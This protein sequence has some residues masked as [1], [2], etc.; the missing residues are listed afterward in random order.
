MLYVPPVTIENLVLNRLKTKIEAGDLRSPIGL[1][2]EGQHI[3]SII[4][5][6]PYRTVDVLPEPTLLDFFIH[7]GAYCKILRANLAMTAD[8]IRDL[9]PN[10]DNLI[11]LARDNPNATLSDNVF[12]N[13]PAFS[14]YI[15][16][17]V[18][19]VGDIG[20]QNALRDSEF[21]GLEFFLK[22]KVY[23]GTIKYKYRK[24]KYIIDRIGDIIIKSELMNRGQVTDSI[25]VYTYSG[26]LPLCAK[27]R[28]NYDEIVNTNIT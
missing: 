21:N 17:K 16:Q 10:L 3:A 20:L 18:H 22:F 25:T 2:H 26:K 14:G 24:Y 11:L 1:L 9:N 8:S 6:L 12:Q 5:T 19:S 4:I 7:T 27:K 28:L 13:A 23:V 15:S